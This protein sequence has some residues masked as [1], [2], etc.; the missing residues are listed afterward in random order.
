MIV[1]SGGGYHG[2]WLL[3]ESQGTSAE[4]ECDL[5]KNFMKCLQRI[6][7]ESGAKLDS[8]GDLSRVLR[9]P[10]TFN[11]KQKPARRV[12]LLKGKIRRYT[13][14]EIEAFVESHL[15]VSNA[16]TKSSSRI[17][18]N[19]DISLQE[20][21]SAVQK[22]SNDR[23]THYRSWIKVGMGIRSAYPDETGLE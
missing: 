16:T 1:D 4:G 5:P 14:A 10:G 19:G 12:K 23:A 3:E 20:L 7:E 13:L 22:L 9:I 2:W 11:R 15:Q 8:V 6:A 21:R 18:N 17:I